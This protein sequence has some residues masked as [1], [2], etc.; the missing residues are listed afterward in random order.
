V[1]ADPYAMAPT[2]LRTLRVRMTVVAGR[3]T[4][5]TQENSK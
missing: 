5:D 1:S 4:F 3:V 2:D